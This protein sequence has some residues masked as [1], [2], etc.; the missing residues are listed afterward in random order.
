MANIIGKKKR[1]IIIIACILLI[2]ALVLTAAFLGILFYKPL[3][4]EPVRVIAYF[5]SG[6]ANINLDT[7]DFAHI[8]HLIYAFAHID[9]TSLKVYIENEDGLRRL[10]HYLKSSFPQVKLMLS[11]ATSAVNDGMCVA[12]H[13][14]TSRANIVTQCRKLMDEYDLVGFDIDWEYPTYSVNDAQRCRNCASD[15]ASLLEDMRHG[16]P[17]GTVL[18]FAGAGAKAIAD[19]YENIRLKKVVNFVNVML[20]DMGMKRHS[21]L[22]DSRSVM[23]HYQLAGYGKNQ[24]NWGLPFYGRCENSECDYL[25]YAQIEELIE[26]GQAKLIQKKDYSHAVYNGNLISFYTK[27][28]IMRKAKYVEKY[29]YGGV[30]CWHLSCDKDNELM[31]ALW[32]ILRN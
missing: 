24:L 19:G 1:I 7:Y 2:A 9:G 27:T 13:T 20:Y 3:L 32:Q 11:I 31:T 8:T 4:D 10:S 5:T 6:S 28:Q 16:L 25:T 21:S 26:T 14:P 12:T 23:F 22:S 30:F 29:G 15:H 17:E 18:S